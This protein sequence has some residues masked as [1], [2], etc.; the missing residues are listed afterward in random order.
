MTMDQKYISKS[1]KE[2][3]C[4]PLIPIIHVTVNAKPT[5]ASPS[6]VIQSVE[7]DDAESEVLDVVELLVLST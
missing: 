5:I 6:Q 1:S 2:T 3:T 4:A 7:V